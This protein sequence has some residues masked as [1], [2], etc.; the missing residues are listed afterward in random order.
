[1]PSMGTSSWYCEDRVTG[2]CR[3]GL[4]FHLRREVIFL[5]FTHE[6]K[7]PISALVSDRRSTTLVRV[8]QVTSLG[9]ALFQPISGIWNY[10][11][12]PLLYLLGS[13]HSGSLT[14]CQG[15]ECSQATMRMPLWGEGLPTPRPPGAAGLTVQTVDRKG[16]HR[17]AVIRSGAWETC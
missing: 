2:I 16:R 14:E 1:M 8:V 17:E 10:I 7:Q 3:N 11:S 6:K 5:K 9:P 4:S 13:D 15:A 12:Y